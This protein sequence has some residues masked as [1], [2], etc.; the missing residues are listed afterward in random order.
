M[1]SDAEYGPD[2]ESDFASLSRPPYAGNAI[3]RQCLSR[4]L[5]G[6]P[7]VTREQVLGL[8]V[9]NLAAENAALRAAVDAVASARPAPPVFLHDAA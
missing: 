7:A 2:R 5:C 1:D 6:E 9:K 8:M 4:W 3:V